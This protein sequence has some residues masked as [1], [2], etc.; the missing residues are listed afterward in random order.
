MKKISQVLF[1][2]VVSLL[3]LT[4]LASAAEPGVVTGTKNLLQDALTWV[5]FLI[6]VGCGCMLAW[7]SFCKS[8]NEG[9]QAQAGIHGRAMKKTLI[10]SAI[11]MSAAGI[12]KAVLSY[13]GS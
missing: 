5:L 3:L 1:S 2:T 11:G 6:P 10:T 4:P 9:D 13:Y 7:H 12:V 8:L